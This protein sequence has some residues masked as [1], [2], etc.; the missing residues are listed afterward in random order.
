MRALLTSTI[1]LIGTAAAFSQVFLGEDY[2]PVE[3]EQVVTTEI[4]SI[5]SS[6]PVDA[7]YA[8][9]ATRVN[10]SL[11]PRVFTGYRHL[12]GTNFKR[13]VTDPVLFMSVYRSL[14]HV[15]NDTVA[16]EELEIE[17]P[18]LVENNVGG[19]DLIGDELVVV[20]PEVEPISEE[21]KI[22]SREELPVA[23]GSATPDWLRR[24]LDSN[25]YQ[26][27]FAYSMMIE[28][29]S[30]IQ[31]AFWNL[32]VPPSLPEE[33]YSFRGF[34]QKLDIPQADPEDLLEV[35]AKGG[36]INWLH[37]VNTALQLSQAYVSGNWYQGGSNYLAFLGSFTWDV[38]LN[39]YYYPNMMFQSTFAYKFS[40]NSTPDDEYHKYSIS[41]DLLQYNMKFGYKAVHNWYYSMN[42][43]FKTQIFNSYPA[44][45]QTRKASFLSPGDFNLGLG[46]TYNKEN[47]AKT[48][49]FS[50]S[51]SPIS[52]NL[53]SCIDPKINETQFGI[54]PGRKFKNE[55]GS[56]AEL[57]FY[58]KLWG[59]ATYTTRLFLFT[60]Y[61]LFQGDWE[62]TINFQFSRFFST[63]IYAHLRYDSSIDSSISKGWKKFMLKEILSFGLTYN[64]STK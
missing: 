53:Q 46:M 39:N 52:Y 30:L 57:N 14:D 17:Q 49:K 54:K 1:L 61:K 41:Q 16:I 42:M 28:E 12:R 24:A 37:S 34:L 18:I 32:P 43:Q 15:N 58:A 62:N 47:K 27:D 29:P 48:L 64:F 26:E 40:I 13:D 31:Y 3:T 11:T 10:K 60:D 9:P 5:L 56:N 44:N 6:L 51:I 33:D 55:V 8:T 19:L 7:K 38:Q 23:F 25:R 4:D 45:S 36:R 63:Q 21:E 20:E 22:L 50:A 2:T 59:K 35:N